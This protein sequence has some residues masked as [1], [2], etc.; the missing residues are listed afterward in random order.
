LLRPT[1]TPVVALNRVVAVAMAAAPVHATMS[2]AVSLQALVAEADQI[3]IARTLSMPCLRDARGRIVTDVE[4]RVERAE[5]GQARPDDLLVVRRLGGELDGIGMRAEGS[6]LFRPDEDQLLF[7][8]GHLD[9]PWLTT[10]ELSQGQMRIFERDTERWIAGGGDGL[11]LMR[12]GS[13]GSLKRA[14]H[15]GPRP[16]SDVL[17][18]VRDLLKA[19]AP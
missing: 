18:E 12:R 14:A 17:A 13:G 7:L 16:L 2:L 5:K 15:R 1:P 9:D 11:A 19:E 8:L 4:L 10:L 6:P 3:V